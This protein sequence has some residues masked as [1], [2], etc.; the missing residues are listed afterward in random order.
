M[1]LLAGRK[2]ENPIIF[3]IFYY[4]SRPEQSQ[5]SFSENLEVCVAAKKQLLKGEK[6]K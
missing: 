6:S 1:E 3:E 4:P 5:A 2:Y